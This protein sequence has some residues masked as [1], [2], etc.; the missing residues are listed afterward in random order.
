MNIHSDFICN[1]PKQETIQMEMRR[2]KKAGLQRSMGAVDM[3][4]VMVSCVYTYVDICQ[5]VHFKCVQ[6]IVCQLY[7]N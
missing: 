1:S 5:I 4:P 3:S 7:C 2:D 6:F